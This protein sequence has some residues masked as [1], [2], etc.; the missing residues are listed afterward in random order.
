[1]SKTNLNHT[2]KHTYRQ[3]KKKRLVRQNDFF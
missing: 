1:M 2:D 3:T